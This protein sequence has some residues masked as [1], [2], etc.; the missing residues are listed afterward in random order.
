[1]TDQPSSSPS[2]GSTLRHELAERRGS[3]LGWLCSAYVVGRPYGL[4]TRAIVSAHFLVFREALR[5]VAAPTTFRTMSER[6]VA[7][8]SY[9]A[10]T[11]LALMA[12]SCAEA[13]SPRCSAIKSP[14]KD[15]LDDVL[16][17]TRSINSLSS[18]GVAF[19]SFNHRRS[20]EGRTS[21]RAA[22]LK[23]CC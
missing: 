9:S 22:I 6:F 3:S 7:S 11:A 16:A 19:S 23:R 4:P 21:R 15:S 13:S 14:T 17:N 5:A 20:A 8:R 1:M 12:S 2:V 18:W 10:C